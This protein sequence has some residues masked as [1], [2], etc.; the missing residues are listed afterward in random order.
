MSVPMRARSIS[1]A[2][3]KKCRLDSEGVYYRKAGAT[4]D[5]DF[6]Q[7]SHQVALAKRHEY[8]LAELIRMFS[9]SNKFLQNLKLEVRR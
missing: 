3:I 8:L 1:C 5:F 2:D 7:G 9:N 6:S 4:I